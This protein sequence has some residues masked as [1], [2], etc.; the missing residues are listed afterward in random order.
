MDRYEGAKA[1]SS[2]R[3]RNAV[4]RVHKV[5]DAGDLDAHAEATSEGQT[6]GR[7]RKDKEDVLKESGPLAVRGVPA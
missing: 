5:P 7:R 6:D 3:W 1:A 4:G 2:G